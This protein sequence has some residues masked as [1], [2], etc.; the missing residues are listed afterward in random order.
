MNTAYNEKYFNTSE[1]KAFDA[2]PVRIRDAIMKAPR[3][4]VAEY[5][6]ERLRTLSE[7]EVLEEILKPISAEGCT[8]YATCYFSNH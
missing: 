1:M 8:P 7:E 6:L 3:Q 4:Y 5:I 2:L